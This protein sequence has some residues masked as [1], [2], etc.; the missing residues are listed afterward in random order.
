MKVLQSSRKTPTILALSLD[1]RRMEA[2]VVRR[3]N[4]SV[5]AGPAVV[6]D[7]PGDPLAGDLDAAAR[8]LRAGLDEAG[9]RERRCV[10]GLPLHWMFVVSTPLPDL[11]PEDTASLLELEAERH[12]PQALENL[13]V[14]RIPF[15]TEGVGRGM[16][17]M[18]VT[19]ER[20]DRLEALLRAAR[21]VPA[22]LTVAL[23][24]LAQA[25]GGSTEG[26]AILAV[27][28]ETVSLGIGSAGGLGTMRCL[29]GV[30]DLVEGS[31]VI[32]AD[33]VARELRVSLGQ[34]GAAFRGALRGIRILGG[35]EAAE[36]L[37]R[38]LQPR[39]TALGLTVQ[40]FAGDSSPV[41][42]VKLPPGRVPTAALVLGAQHLGQPRSPLEFLPVR[43]SA[44]QQF[45]A[46]TSSR[47]LGHAGLV[48]GALAAVV[49]LAFA[50]QQV[51]LSL[52]R[53]EWAGMSARVRQIEDLQLQI[54]R[55]RPWFDES[56][57]TL[58]ILRRLTESFPE[59]GNVTARSIEIRE[60]NLVSCSGTARDNN[61]LL[62]TLD[63]L[64][65]VS[66]ISDVQVEQL[67]GRSPLQFTFNF[68]WEGPASNP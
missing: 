54:K 21:L 10:V 23:P 7:L 42:G 38:D 57:R 52:L 9:I 56:H 5:E 65:A 14:A 18:A 6:L 47:K 41:A 59:D 40:R 19:R 51:R 44:W 1:G 22:S 30:I 45:T 3:T 61:A 60:G 62:R 68:R 55:Y 64:R 15:G 32:R 27:G 12:F 24:P 43:P 66:G 53:R 39:A 13:M 26:W 67:R 49:I 48:A 4:G 2:V 58:N 35:G 63:Q 34:V 33:V 31:P 50:V 29:S 16:L 8:A 25:C 46:R 11:S 37:A 17:Q 28:E 36:R 20:I